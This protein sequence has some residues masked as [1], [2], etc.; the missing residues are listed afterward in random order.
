MLDSDG[1]SAITQNNTPS[2]PCHLEIPLGRYGS[3]RKADELSRNIARPIMRREG[4]P[5]VVKLRLEKCG[6]R[7]L[8]IHGCVVS[9]NLIDL[10]GPSAKLRVDAN[11]ADIHYG[12]RPGCD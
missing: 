8:V 1:R 12:P 5:K 10:H 11:L 4:W 3:S 7:K 9:I 2:S 6:D